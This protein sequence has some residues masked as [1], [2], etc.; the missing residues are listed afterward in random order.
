MGLKPLLHI[1]PLVAE[2]GAQV[3]QKE[4]SKCSPVHET[5]VLVNESDR[6]LQ[7][8]LDTSHPLVVQGLSPIFHSYISAN[9]LQGYL[10][11]SQSKGSWKQDKEQ[12]FVLLFAL[13]TG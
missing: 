2:F 10:L 13:K 5:L 12:Q 3:V 7:W 11:Y 8:E 4:G 9:S 6:P 1:T